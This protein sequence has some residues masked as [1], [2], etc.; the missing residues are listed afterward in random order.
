MDKFIKSSTLNCASLTLEF[1]SAK[2]FHQNSGL[3]AL[4]TS[5]SLLEDRPKPASTF[6]QFPDKPTCLCILKPTGMSTAK[7]KIPN[8][9]NQF[10]T[11]V[12]GRGWMYENLIIKLTSEQ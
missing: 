12:T 2:A 7:I 6:S 3:T 5:H 8:S 9:S 4:I 1:T 11:K 10:S